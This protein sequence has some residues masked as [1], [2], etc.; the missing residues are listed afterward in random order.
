MSIIKAKR[1]PYESYIFGWYLPEKFCNDVLRWHKHNPDLSKTGVCLDRDGNSGQNDS[2]KKST[3]KDFNVITAF[4]LYK[5]YLKYLDEGMRAYSQTYPM[6]NLNYPIKETEGVNF[7]HYKPT[8]GFKVWHA[9]R[10]CSMKS[11]RVMVFMTYLN[12][13]DNGGTEFYHQNL[14]VNAEKGLTLLWPSDWIH[15]HR[16]I[17]TK[18][19]NKF[20]LTGWLNYERE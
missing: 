13:V 20:I 8:E 17:I 1:F 14:K 2:Y 3:D 10:L 5:K 7:Q 11:L 18:K 4:E 12:D 19:Q 9:E 6:F 15:T 16:G